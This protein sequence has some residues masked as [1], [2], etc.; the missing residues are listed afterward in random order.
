[1]LQIVEEIE[2]F[3][4][5]RCVSVPLDSGLD[6]CH[7][8][9]DEQP[10]SFAQERI[11]TW[12]VLERVECKE[13]IT[14]GQV[15]TREEAGSDVEGEP[16]AHPGRY[17][18][19]DFDTNASVSPLGQGFEQDARRAP[20]LDHR[21]SKRPIPVD[22]AKPRIEASVSSVELSSPLDRGVTF[23]GLASLPV[24]VE[25]VELGKIVL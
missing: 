3:A 2:S 6:D 4:E 23:E 12:T 1:M 14:R 15:H 11:R 10:G 13:E 24:R 25:G 18:L 5:R 9:R 17:R 8:P 7:S 19:R 21:P 20:D 16:V 22:E